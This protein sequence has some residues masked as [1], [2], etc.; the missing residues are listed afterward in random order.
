MEAQRRVAAS[1]RP[2]VKATKHQARQKGFAEPAQAQRLDHR[3]VK[4]NVREVPE[5]R[6]ISP[7]QRAAKMKG[8]LRSDQLGAS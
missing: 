1:G 7:E 3:K 5:K 8:R 2:Q 6:W 4:S